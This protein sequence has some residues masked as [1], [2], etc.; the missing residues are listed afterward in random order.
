MKTYSNDPQDYTLEDACIEEFNNK[1]W[2]ELVADMIHYFGNN[3]YALDSFKEWWVEQRIKE[4]ENEP[5]DY[6]Y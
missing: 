1:D 2:L 6:D 5:K 3:E 4:I